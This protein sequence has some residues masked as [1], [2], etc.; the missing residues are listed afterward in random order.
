MSSNKTIIP[1]SFFDENS[2]NFTCNNKSYNDLID[3]GSLRKQFIRVIPN[4]YINIKKKGFSLKRK[5]ISGTEE[6]K[7]LNEEIITLKEAIF[8]LR[9]KKR[10][11]IEQIEELRNL[12]RKIG[13]KKIIIK[14]KKQINNNYS[15]REKNEKQCFVCENRNS[16]N[17]NFKESSD[18]AEDSIA[19]IISGLTSEKDQVPGCDEDGYQNYKRGS[20]DSISSNNNSTSCWSFNNEGNFYD[21]VINK[22]N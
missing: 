8:D 19:P 17:R 9:E 12:M 11:K 20:L 7:K 1:I 4:Y 6:Y 22:E 2:N 15:N 16:R 10:K 18:D 3:Y 5:Y 13:S 14:D 21:K